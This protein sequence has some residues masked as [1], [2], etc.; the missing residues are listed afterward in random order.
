MYASEFSSSSNYEADAYLM[1]EQ[2]INGVDGI[3]YTSLHKD[4]FTTLNIIEPKNEG[5]LNLYGENLSDEEEKLV[6][7]IF[8]TVFFKQ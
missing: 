6:V 4:G 7:E 8:E 2:N 3:I 1:T 5:S